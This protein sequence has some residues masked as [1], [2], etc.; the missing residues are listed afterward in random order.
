MAHDHSHSCFYQR[1]HLI[2][3]IFSELWHELRASY[4]ARHEPEKIK[5]LADLYWRL[6]LVLTL[7]LIVS[8]LIWGV[9]KFIDVVTTL[10]TAPA[11][12][13]TPPVALDRKKLETALEAYA[14]RQHDFNQLKVAPASYPDP[15]R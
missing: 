11:G 13:G 15:S 10:S 3:S 8:V 9:F 7:I 1:N 2:M 6:L 4:A 12:S 14:A 5:P